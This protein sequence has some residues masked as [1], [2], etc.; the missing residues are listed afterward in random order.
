MHYHCKVFC[1][2]A[3][4]MMMLVLDMYQEIEYLQGLWSVAEYCMT[5]KN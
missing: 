2:F 4:H 3:E 5:E 1:Y